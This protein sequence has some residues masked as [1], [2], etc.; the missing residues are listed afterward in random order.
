MKLKS[1]AISDSP[2]RLAILVLLLL[3]TLYLYFFSKQHEVQI[4]RALH[5]FLYRRGGRQESL[6]YQGQKRTYLVH[7]P[8]RLRFQ[9]AKPLLIVLHGSGGD[10]YDARNSLYINHKANR[11]KFM[12]V[13]PD[14]SGDETNQSFN[15]NAGNCCGYSRDHN[16]DD[17]GFIRA[18]IEA[19]KRKYKVDPD[20]IYVT[21]FSAG[22]IMAY[23]IGCELSDE[24][25]AVAPVAGALDFTEC[26]PTNPVSV[27]AFNGTS[28]QFVLYKGGV[29]R[30]D[31][32][33]NYD[34]PVSYAI[35]FWVKHNHC[36][37]R[38]I[39]AQHGN[40]IRKS[41]TSG[42]NGTEVV[43][44]TIVGGSHAWPGVLNGMSFDQLQ[45]SDQEISAIDEILAFFKNHFKNETQ[46]MVHN[47]PH[48]L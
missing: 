13:Y 17:T 48:R 33:K 23:R 24:V 21:G 34:Q 1:T 40:V 16:I 36:S 8:L 45:R 28:D 5:R 7:I 30:V 2:L 6:I 22:G 14:G 11:A 26:R 15:W 18:M 41:Y 32:E 38:P 43:L 47:S 4:Q 19:L 39:K 46:V 29:S 20:R 10:S 3:V 25:A 42:K 9:P 35:K 44:Y 12:V 37:T 31:P 27:I